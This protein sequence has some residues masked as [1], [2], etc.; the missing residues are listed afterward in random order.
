VDKCLILAS[1]LPSSRFSFLRPK[2]EKEAPA[3]DPRAAAQKAAQ[4][5]LAAQKVRPLPHFTA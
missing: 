2:V 5:R 4:E 1:L 3:V